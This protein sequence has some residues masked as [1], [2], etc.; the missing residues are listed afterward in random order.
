M[1]LYDPATG[2]FVGGED[3]RTVK[4]Y[5]D[6]SWEAY[7]MVLPEPKRGC[8]ATRWEAYMDRRMVE[9]WLKESVDV[10]SRRTT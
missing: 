9:G 7:P 10:I 2:E 8:Y 6:G 4:L 1:R 5:V 3:S